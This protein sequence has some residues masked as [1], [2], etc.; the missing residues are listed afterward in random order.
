MQ[1]S[2]CV[3]AASLFALCA[4][5]SVAQDTGA[6]PMMVERAAPAAA[7]VASLPANT[8]VYLSLNEELSTKGNWMDVG[9][10]FG[11]TVVNDVM[12]GEY[13]VIPKGS[14]AT[15]AVTWMTDKGM[16]GKSGKFE[17]EISSVEVNG[18]RIPLEGTFRQ[19]GEGNTVA[20]IGAVVVAPVVGFFVTGKSGR[21]ARGTELTVF[22]GED[23]D[24]QFAGPPP[25][26]NAPMV[27]GLTHQAVAAAP[28]EAPVEADAEAEA[29]MVEAVAQEPAMI[30]DPV[31]QE[32]EEDVAAETE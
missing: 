17:I 2:V 19:E 3:A 14:R 7:N 27:V 9:H 24:V 22:T 1:N 28:V 29:E 30:S 16:F 13:V 23:I 26:Q 21:M 8:E 4:A 5:P 25:V 20:T 15:G 18:R 6:A 12:L 10:T 32:A 11:L 31:V